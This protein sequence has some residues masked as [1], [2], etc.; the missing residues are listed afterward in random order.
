MLTKFSIK[1]FV[2]NIRI[3]NPKFICVAYNIKLFKR[4]LKEKKNLNNSDLTGR[5]N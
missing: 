5:R 4:L 2:T 3:H 1:V